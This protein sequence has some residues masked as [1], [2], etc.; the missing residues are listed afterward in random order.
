MSAAPTGDVA[1]TALMLSAMQLRG[2]AVA[3][4]LV[5]TEPLTLALMG[6]AVLADPTAA[7]HSGAARICTMAV[8]VVMKAIDATPSSTANAVVLAACPM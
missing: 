7:G 2:F 4:A 1:D 5:K 3:T 8:D 6:A